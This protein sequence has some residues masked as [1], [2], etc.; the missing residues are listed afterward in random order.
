MLQSDV[1][2]GYVGLEEHVLGED[3]RSCPVKLVYVA[4]KLFNI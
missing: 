2:Y 3:F 1:T 4:F